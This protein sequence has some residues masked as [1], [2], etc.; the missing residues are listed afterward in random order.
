MHLSTFA[1]PT[2]PP[3]GK[4]LQRVLHA[5]DD[6]LREAHTKAQAARGL[7]GIVTKLGTWDPS[8]AP[9][10]LID[11][12][13]ALASISTRIGHADT[14]LEDGNVPLPEGVARMVNVLDATKESVDRAVGFTSALLDVGTLPKDTTWSSR[15]GHAL[16][17][18]VSQ[19]QLAYSLLEPA[20]R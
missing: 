10:P 12:H 18:A 14:L 3:R 20:L 15:L 5:L 2:Q 1:P 17:A 4:Q 7:M 6:N 16:D 13:T 8:S 9:Q 19:T 11:L